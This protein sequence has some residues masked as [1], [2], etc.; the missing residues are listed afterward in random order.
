M[1]R[2]DKRGSEQ[3]AW[4]I[5]SRADAVYVA[6]EG[7]DGP[8]LRPLHAVVVGSGPDRRLVFH[9]APA[10]DKA[11]G[12]GRRVAVMAHEHVARLP[13][14][15][16]HGEKACPATTLY[17]SASAHGVLVPIDDPAAKADLLQGLME[18]HQPEGG[19]RPITH[20]DPMYRAAVTGLGVWAVRPDRIVSKVA[21]HQSKRQDHRRR[22]VQKLWDRGEPGDAHAAQ[23]VVD[24][25]PLQ[26]LADLLRGPHG[27]ELVLAP[28]EP[29]LDDVVA[30]LRDQY[31]N[32]GV[33]DPTLRVAHLGSPVWMVLQQEGRVVATARALTD[34][35][36]TSYVADVAVDEAWQGKRLG[37]FLMERMVEHPRLRRTRVDLLTRTA[38]PFYEQLGFMHMSWSQPW[39]FPTP[40]RPAS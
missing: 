16:T 15:F 25:A 29:H 33:D 10:G 37:R 36:K 3:L 34:G 32:T 23:L 31:W 28:G 8:L 1:R 14:F 20:D 35:H 40:A 38:G 2:E 30:L 5:L 12:V 4:Q 19:H 7:E 13:S 18:R 17:R 24:A 27:T 22:L 26:P 21:L 9:G 39:R 6:M 11:Q